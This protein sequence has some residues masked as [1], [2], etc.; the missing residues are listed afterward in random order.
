[1]KLAAL[2][3]QQRCG[4]RYRRG[5]ADGDMAHIADGVGDL[6]GEQFFGEELHLRSSRSSCPALCLASTTSLCFF[7]TWMAGTSPAMT[8]S[9]A[10]C[11]SLT[12]LPT[13][14]LNPSS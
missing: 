6:V 12:Y 13:Y 3:R 1:L 8:K 2:A 11:L 7:K 4:R 14:S 9:Y 10:G 5:I